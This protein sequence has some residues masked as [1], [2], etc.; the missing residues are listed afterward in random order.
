[1]MN[2]MMVV[3]GNSMEDLRNGV[4]AMEQ[5]MRSGA[6]MGVGGSSLA[7]IKSGMAM[8]EQMMGGCS[9]CEDEDE[10]LEAI[11]EMLADYG[12][13]NTGIEEVLDIIYEHRF[14]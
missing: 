2:G 4:E 5:A 12:M 7:D 3:C 14:Q 13:D 11:V 8:M 10:I 9:C 1:M 6:V